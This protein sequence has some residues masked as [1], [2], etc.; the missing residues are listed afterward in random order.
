MTLIRGVPIELALLHQAVALVVLTA[1]TLHAVRTVGRS[2]G[3]AGGTPAVP[4]Q[5]I[6]PAY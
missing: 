2:A 5:Q 3:S 4:E 6:R 1:A